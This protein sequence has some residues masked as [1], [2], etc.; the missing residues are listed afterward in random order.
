MLLSRGL[1]RKRAT[2]RIAD[3]RR[4]LL[5]RET[6]HVIYIYMGSHVH[7]CILVSEINTRSVFILEMNRIW[8]CFKPLSIRSMHFPSPK[9]QILCKCRR[10]RKDAPK[11]DLCSILFEL[12]YQLTVDNNVKKQKKNICERIAFKLAVTSNR[13]SSQSI[14][15]RTCAFVEIRFIFSIDYNLFSYDC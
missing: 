11:Q 14:I 3:Q 13:D 10:K 9:R 12:Y 1:H 7:S 8:C 5:S 2:M 15:A 6:R 4:A